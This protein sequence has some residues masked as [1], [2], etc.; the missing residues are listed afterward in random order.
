MKVEKQIIAIPVLFNQEVL[1][2]ELELTRI[3]FDDAGICES[4]TKT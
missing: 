2:R 1:V 3:D 4:K